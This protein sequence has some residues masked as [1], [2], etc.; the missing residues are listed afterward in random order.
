VLLGLKRALFISDPPDQPTMSGISHGRDS[1]AWGLSPM[2][3]AEDRE[4]WSGPDSGAHGGTRAGRGNTASDASKRRRSPAPGSRMK[5]SISGGASPAVSGG[6][7]AVAGGDRPVQVC[8]NCGTTKTPLWRKDKETGE[9]NCNACGIYK[10]T[11][12]YPRP[13]NMRPAD[14]AGG[15]SGAVAGGGSQPR[16]VPAKGKRGSH[17][18]GSGLG[19]SP[20]VMSGYSGTPPGT[21]S[22]LHLPGTGPQHRR[23]SAGAY[24]GKPPLPPPAIRPNFLTSPPHA[25]TGGTGSTPPVPAAVLPPWTSPPPAVPMFGMR[26]PGMAPGSASPSPDQAPRPPPAVP[27]LSNPVH[28]GPAVQYGSSSTGE[29]PSS[30]APTVVKGWPAGLTLP[31]GSSAPGA[32]N[33]PGMPATSQGVP[34]PPAIGAPAA[35]LGLPIGRVCIQGVS[36]SHIQRRMHM[37]HK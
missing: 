10:Q 16:S 14:S 24:P 23:L 3:G 27:M 34:R 12:G 33:V 22:G 36:D 25:S 15:D 17:G 18:T 6:G 26:P 29:V 4:Y 35:P 1:P 21:S 28:P 5:A 9:S 8:A 37:R 30:G 7:G 20:G 19:T 11:H 2:R 31:P 32:M 13:V